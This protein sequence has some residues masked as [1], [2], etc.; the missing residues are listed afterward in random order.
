MVDYIEDRSERQIEME[1]NS[2]GIRQMDDWEVDALKRKEYHLIY[3]EFYSDAL[4]LRDMS[5]RIKDILPKWEE[6]VA[7]K[8][9]EYSRTIFIQIAQACENACLK[10]QKSIEIEIYSEKVLKQ[11]FYELK[12]ILNVSYKWHPAINSGKLFIKVK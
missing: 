9:E 10:G 5:S 11:V 1:S 4:Y 7:Y 12:V 2:L 6:T 8:E 3:P